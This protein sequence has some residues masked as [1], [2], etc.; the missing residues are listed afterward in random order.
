MQTRSVS[1]PGIR[2]HAGRHKPSRGANGCPE[3]S[4]IGR[5]ETQS[6]TTPSGETAAVGEAT[7]LADVSGVAAASGL[8]EADGSGLVDAEG[9][10]EAVAA[11][12]GTGGCS[13]VVGVWGLDTSYQPDL[14]CSSTA[15][16][17]DL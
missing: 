2:E 8:G 12:L 15:R 9:S 3:C 5:T 13:A 1:I 16:T 11:G 6:V 10:G 14:V 7:G 4:R 17:A